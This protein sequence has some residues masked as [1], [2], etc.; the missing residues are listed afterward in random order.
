[1]WRRSTLRSGPRSTGPAS[2]ATSS[3][4]V[5][6]CPKVW[7]ADGHGS[8]GGVGGVGVGGGGRRTVGVGGGGG[9]GGGGR[10]GVAVVGGGVFGVCCDEW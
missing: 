4:P 9:G 8:V 3:P 1:M 2:W 5:C 7:P 6:S 10:G